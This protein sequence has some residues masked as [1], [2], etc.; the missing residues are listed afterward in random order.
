MGLKDLYSIYEKLDLDKVGVDDFAEEFPIEGDLP[1]FI[2]YLKRHRFEELTFRNNTDVGA[3]INLF[4]RSHGKAFLCND[5]SSLKWVRFANTRDRKVSE[6]NP[7]F[8]IIMD[9]G[10]DD[11]A[12]YTECERYWEN[13]LS[14]RDWHKELKKCF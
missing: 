7:I 13:E 1:R 14:A 10:A 11:Y 4:D 3:L 12:F 8:S 5:G 2:E 9:Y 6:K